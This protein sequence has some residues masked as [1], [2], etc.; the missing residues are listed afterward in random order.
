MR[1][2]P[3]FVLAAAILAPA[4][5]IATTPAGAA[6][7]V[8][9]KAISGKVTWNPPVPA[10]PATKTSNTTLVATFTGCSG[11]PGV[12]KGTVK[13]PT[14][15]G[16]TKGNCTTLLGK[17]TK[18]TIPK[19]GTITW[20]KGAKS[21]LA[22][23]TLT[24]TKV[25]AQYKAVVKVSAGQFAGK[26]ITLTAGFKPNGCPLSSATLSLAK[27]TKIAIK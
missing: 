16:T 26:T 22:V 3:A 24:P 11:T 23:L 25:A 14:I 20:N 1:K 7:G 12:T 8:A 9:C 6:G 5:F 10:A 21:T 17:P 19:G 27:G 15:V 18:I 2:I 13:V 4:T